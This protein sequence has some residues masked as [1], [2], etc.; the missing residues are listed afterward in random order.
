MFDFLCHFLVQCGFVTVKGLIANLSG[1]K[2]IILF[3]HTEASAAMLNCSYHNWRNSQKS[4]HPTP[5]YVLYMYE[6][7]YS[8]KWI[9]F[10]P[11]KRWHQAG[12]LDGVLRSFTGWQAAHTKVR[13]LFKHTPP[14]HGGYTAKTLTNKR[15]SAQR[16]VACMHCWKNWLK[17]VV[18]VTISHC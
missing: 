18:E 16:S 15:V 7:V 14:F 6:Y 12:L 5:E 11:I 13:T 10:N 2:K 8:F 3:Y 17:L 4:S 1:P 9:K